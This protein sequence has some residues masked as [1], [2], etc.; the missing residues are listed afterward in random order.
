MVN[1]EL[2]DLMIAERSGSAVLRHGKGGKQ[3]NVP[4]PLPAR[5]A[6]QA[7][8]DTRPPV[9]SP[10]V[11]IG[12]R[13]PLTCRGIRALCDKYSAI[14][15]IELHPHLLRHT[16]AHQY[17]DDNGQRSCTARHTGPPATK[18]FPRLPDTSSE[19]SRA[20]TAIDNCDQ[21]QVR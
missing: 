10:R 3:R 16:M 11:F 13:G 17:L 7:Y 12:E 1:L 6:L 19:L 4:L 9:P 20:Q 2:T 18:I 14:T 15:G 5:R 8:L 21:E